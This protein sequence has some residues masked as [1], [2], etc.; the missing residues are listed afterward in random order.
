MA[1]K[2]TVFCLVG[3]L[4]GGWQIRLATFF[5]YRA[6]ARG[7]AGPAL[8]PFARA[9]KSWRQAAGGDYYHAVLPFGPLR[10]R[11]LPPPS[12]LPQLPP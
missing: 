11:R 3:V 10:P 5:C 7:N 12:L 1:A 8:A 9:N 4:T 2:L 6:H